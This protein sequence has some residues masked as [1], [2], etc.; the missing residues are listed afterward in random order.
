MWKF[1]QQKFLKIETPSHRIPSIVWHEGWRLS[2]TNDR[3][4]QENQESGAW[5]YEGE[6]RKEHGI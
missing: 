2:Y 5:K 4:H 3:S 6:M 1:K